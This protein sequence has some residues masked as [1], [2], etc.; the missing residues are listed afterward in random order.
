MWSRRRRRSARSKALRRLL[1]EHRFSAA[2]GLLGA[3]ALTLGLWLLWPAGPD[4]AAGQRDR[5]QETLRQRH[6]AVEQPEA[7]GAA[8]ISIAEASL[9]ISARRELDGG[10][11]I[12]TVSLADRRLARIADTMPEIGPPTRRFPPDVDEFVVRMPVVEPDIAD[13]GGV[14]VDHGTVNGAPP[15]VGVPN[16]SDGHAWLRYAAVEPVEDG[17]PKIAIVIDDLGNDRRNTAALNRLPGPLTLAFLDFRYQGPPTARAGQEDFLLLRMTQ[18]LQA[19]GR[20]TI[21]E[22]ALLDK[23]LAELKLSSSEL[24]DPQAALRVGKILSARLIATGSLIYPGET[25]QFSVRLIETE[26]TRVK[27]SATEIVTRPD[28]LSDVVAQVAQTLA[29]T[30]R[31]TYPLQ[32]R[33]VQVVPEGIFVNL[34]AERGMAPGL[35]LQVFGEESPLH[36]DGKVV[37]YRREPVGFLEVTSVEGQFAQAKVLQLEPQATL[38]PGWKVKEVQE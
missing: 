13:L 32:G 4:P 31:H 34:G 2:E 35:M 17:R 5:W 28:R 3:A 6:A 21:V 14:D 19:D 9:A 30:L 24:T 22:R 29:D 23:L 25:G 1:I 18:A 16:R 27:A 7:L 10:V 33:I 36:I 8:P 20:V 12:A 11:G 15:L 37:G 38:Q 26:T